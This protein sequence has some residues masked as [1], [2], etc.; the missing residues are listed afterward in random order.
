[1]SYYTREPDARPASDGKS[2]A[3]K[4]D[5]DTYNP[6]SDKEFV[7]P[8]LIVWEWRNGL[9]QNA[10]D[11]IVRYIYWSVV[12]AEKHG[13]QF[14]KSAN[15]IATRLGQGV[16]VD[17]VHS[18][19]RRTKILE[20][21]GKIGERLSQRPW[22]LTSSY[23]QNASDQVYGG[24]EYLGQIDNPPLSL[25]Q[26]SIVNLTTRPCQFDNSISIEHIEDNIE[27]IENQKG[28]RQKYLSSSVSM[29]IGNKSEA[30]GPS[31]SSGS[32]GQSSGYSGKPVANLN[33]KTRGSFSGSL[34]GSVSGLTNGSAVGS[35]NGPAAGSFSGPFSGS[36][37]GP[38]AGSFTVSANGPV[39]GSDELSAEI[40]LADAGGSVNGLLDVPDDPDTPDGIPM[41]SSD[42]SDRSD[43][44]D[45]SDAPVEESDE[46]EDNHSF[47][48]EL[49]PQIWDVNDFGKI[50]PAC[51]TF[52]IPIIAEF[53]STYM[54]VAEVNKTIGIVLKNGPPDYIQLVIAVSRFFSPH[55]G[56]LVLSDWETR[57]S[58]VISK[59][60][61]V[62]PIYES[63][64]AP[65]VEGIV[66]ELLERRTGGSATFRKGNGS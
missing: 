10:S 40:P 57:F 46:A 8:T 54:C 11:A 2:F 36:L 52:G 61:H 15:Y 56:G 7:N 12:L 27:D 19:L 23:N 13:R 28:L 31:G 49:A 18:A 17:A 4:V 64:W 6:M 25:R 41:F 9:I 33:A 59:A 55:T 63:D 47:F 35:A 1:M 48:E 44:P 32:S 21:G 22:Q 30:I 50:Y 66:A 5:P 26:P 16:T 60:G 65:D 53:I 38:A 51:K 39:V 62:Q 14:D 58:S 29:G 20:R 24:T 3:P 34:T 37:T 45:H 42:R 43:R